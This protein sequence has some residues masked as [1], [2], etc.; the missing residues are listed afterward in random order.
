MPNSLWSVSSCIRRAAF[1][2]ATKKPLI[3]VST[4]NYISGW[5]TSL[6]ISRDIQRDSDH[7]STAAAV[8]FELFSDE[9]DPSRCTINTFISVYKC[10]IQLKHCK[11]VAVHSPFK[12]KMCESDLWKTQ[13]SNTRVFFYFVLGEDNWKHTHTHTT[14]W[15]SST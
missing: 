14:R 7:D 1:W 15:K 13:I 4:A 6:Q 11:P 2:C 3:T 8:E 10:F 5:L 9:T 12:W